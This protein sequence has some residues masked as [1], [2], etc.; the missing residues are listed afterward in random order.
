MCSIEMATIEGNQL[1]ALID[2]WDMASLG[3]V[4][5]GNLG[6]VEQIRA[7]PSRPVL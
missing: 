2:T 6:Q 3:A 5:A 1:R 4:G 7:L